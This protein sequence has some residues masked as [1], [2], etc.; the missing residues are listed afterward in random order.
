MPI[1]LIEAIWNDDTKT[2]MTYCAKNEFNQTLNNV[3]TEG[4]E[5]WQDTIDKL[6]GPE[7]ID[8]FTERKQAM[9]L[10]KAKNMHPHI[11]ELHKR[12]D[13]VDSNLDNV[14]AVDSRVENLENATPAQ[15]TDEDR[16]AAKL[17]E[18][19][20]IKLE[21]FEIEEVQ[22][23]ENKILRSKIRKSQNM[24]ELNAWVTAI[25]LESLPKEDE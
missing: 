15:L 23:S 14:K 22:R 12:L 9:D 7:A 17:K 20:T 18:L 24:I 3:I 4:H 25:L 2:S 6:G 5:E 1:Q 13:S 10:E 8:Q 19:F 21:A 11:E 16:K